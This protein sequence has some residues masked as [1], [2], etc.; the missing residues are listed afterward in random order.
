MSSTSS[1]RSASFNYDDSLLESSTSVSSSETLVP[2]LRNLSGQAILAVGKAEIAGLEALW[3]LL[4]GKKGTSQRTK[5]TASSMDDD[6]LVDSTSTS[7]YSKA[8]V[9]HSAKWT[10]T[11]DGTY[12]QDIGKLSGKAIYAVG[13]LEIAGVRWIWT[14]YQRSVI[15]SK[16]PHS[17][18]ATIKGLDDMYDDLLYFC[19]YVECIHPEKSWQLNL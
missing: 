10:F 17:P 13:K 1:G 7:T 19:G 3:K 2:H 8:S 11:S 4:R 6:T 18:D 9:P 16:F 14:K 15:S 5:R 12:V